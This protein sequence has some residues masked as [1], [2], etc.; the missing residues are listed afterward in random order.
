MKTKGFSL[1]LIT[2]SRA[3]AACANLKELRKGKEIHDDVVNMG[4][5]EKKVILCIALV[6]MYAKFGMLK[7][8]HQ[9]LYHICISGVVTWNAFDCWLCPMW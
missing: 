5:L 2:F 6:D 4:L 7:T 3:L 1:D 9:V 8:I